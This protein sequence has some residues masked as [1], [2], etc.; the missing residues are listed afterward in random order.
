MILRHPPSPRLRR[1]RLLMPR[2]RRG[3]TLRSGVAAPGAHGQAAIADLDAD[4][5]PLAVAFRGAR[6]TQVVLLAQFIS[7]SL[8]GGPQTV[9]SLDD[10]RPSPGV[11]RD[12]SQRVCVHS[13]A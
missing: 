13:I 4:G 5:M 10:L 3:R 9:R 1:G 12:Q 7:D 8:G 11:V 2:L 6:I